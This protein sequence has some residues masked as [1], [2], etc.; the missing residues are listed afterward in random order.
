MLNMNP[1]TLSLALGVAVVA[2]FALHAWS[3]ELLHA[4][5]PVDPST[6]IETTAEIQKKVKI[7]PTVTFARTWEE[8]VAEAKMLH[9][10]MVVHSHGFY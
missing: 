10:P 2:P 6:R 4:K 7:K 8:A 3:G 9:L 5:S 1:K